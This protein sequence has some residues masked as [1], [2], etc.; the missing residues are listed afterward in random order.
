MAP[1]QLTRLHLSRKSFCRCI[2][3]PDVESSNQHSPNRGGANDARSGNAGQSIK[4]GIS[5]ARREA[6]IENC[7]VGRAAILTIASR[8]L[9][10]NKMP[11]DLK[12]SNCIQVFNDFETETLVCSPWKSHTRHGCLSNDSN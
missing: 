1:L 3:P 10:M 6:A 4:R 11:R 5:R 9:P 7:A 8:Q 12:S 2:H